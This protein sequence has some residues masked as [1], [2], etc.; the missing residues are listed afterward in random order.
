[1]EAMTAEF[2]EEERQMILLCLAWVT[3]EHPG[4][5]WFL[6]EIAER[7]QG[8]KM[9]EDFKNMKSNQIGGDE[10]AARQGP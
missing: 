10:I 7:L 2:S 6:G 8:R 1:M 4:W 9:F 3:I 5:G